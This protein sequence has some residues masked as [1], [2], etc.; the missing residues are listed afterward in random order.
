M[1]RLKELRQEKKL[2]QKAIAEMLAV[3]EKTVSRWENEES[4]IK[5][6]KAQQL[7]DYFGV[8]VGYLLGYESNRD[9]R[10]NFIHGTTDLNPDDF[11]DFIRK[12]N[13]LFFNE[14]LQRLSE[15][16]FINFVKY[17]NDCNFYISD[18]DIIL[19]YNLI[20]TLNFNR[21][22]SLLGKTLQ[23]QAGHNK[24]ILDFVDKKDY[25]FITIDDE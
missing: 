2:S 21:E 3:N 8:S 16:N 19:I 23:K 1:N 25:R 7:A 15:E 24:S 11:S 12:E 4:Q 13:D 18:K 22:G 6:E 20:T 9:L 14:N 17:I 10:N 5:P